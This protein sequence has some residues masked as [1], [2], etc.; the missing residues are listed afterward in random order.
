[1]HIMTMEE[2][3]T[4]AQF[5]MQLSIEETKEQEQSID[6]A[7]DEMLAEASLELASFDM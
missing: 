4:Q 6:R 2:Q 5:G 3:V 7:Y 1:M